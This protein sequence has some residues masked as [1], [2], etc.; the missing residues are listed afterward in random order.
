MTATIRGTLVQSSTLAGV[1]TISATRTDVQLGDGIDV[2]I[3]QSNTSKQTFTVT[4]NKVG[5][6]H[7]YTQF[8]TSVDVA[9]PDDSSNTHFGTICNGFSST[10]NSITVTITFPL[11][12]PVA[13]IGVQLIEGVRGLPS[14]TANTGQLQTSITGT[15]NAITSGTTTP[16]K[17][18][19]AWL[20]V[21]MAE[22]VS[23]SSL[24]SIGTGFSD[25]GSGWDFGFGTNLAK[26]ESKRITSQTAIAATFTGTATATDYITMVAIWPESQDSLFFGCGT[27]S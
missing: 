16:D 14:S 13:A 21:G 5:G 8:G 2:W 15:A 20:V 22:D 18:T 12:A 19:N 23:K 1:L 27:T 17:N 26:W 25:N 9:A 7:T 3:A 11:V 4:D 24:P 10:P 6:S